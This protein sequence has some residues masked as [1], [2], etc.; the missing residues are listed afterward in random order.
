M[1]N[2]Y[3]DISIDV[4]F[5]RVFGRRANKPLL[6]AVL[7]EILDEIN[8]VD[9]DYLSPEMTGF[10]RDSKNSR[11]D[12][13]VK[14]D[15]GYELIIE[16]QVSNQGDFKDRAVY[17]ASLPIL[18]EIESGEDRYR[19]TPRY[20]ISILHFSLEH[21]PSPHWE[22][23]FRA[24]YALREQVTAEK[25][26]EAI[27]LV[28]IELVRFKKSLEALDND[29]ERFY[30]CLKHMSEFEEMPKEFKGNQL[31]ENLFRT[32]A[33]ESLSKKDKIKYTQ[34]MTTERDIRNQKAYAR[35]QALAEGRIE[36]IA[37]GEA[38]GEAAGRAK[39]A[40]EVAKEMLRQGLTVDIVSKCT[41]LSVEQIRSL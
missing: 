36:G 35:E 10:D 30:F 18:E 11:M 24:R 2:V 16:M 13:R 17:Y 12:L 4:I 21:I 41:G 27:N 15:T 32:T 39:K 38:R 31:M 23:E 3:M 34:F 5:K 14:T 6:I 7:N 9:L 22:N 40:V 29:K 19:L 33:V 1:A 26:S 20:T 37:I 28:F 25:L 8:I